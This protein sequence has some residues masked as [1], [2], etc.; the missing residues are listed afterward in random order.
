[1]LRHG[2]LGYLNNNNSAGQSS[3]PL[4]QLQATSFSEYFI[5]SWSS[6]SDAV[7]TWDT[8]DNYY[9]ITDYDNYDSDPSLFAYYN[10][11]GFNLNI[12]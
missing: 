2:G 5:V 6:S 3:L 12:N 7:A 9:Y 10:F 4:I 8:V 1:M 11:W